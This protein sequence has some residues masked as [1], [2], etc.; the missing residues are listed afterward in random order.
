MMGCMMRMDSM[1]GST[2]GNEMRM[3]CKCKMARGVAPK[4]RPD[5]E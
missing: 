4:D 3:S 2:S 5:L 1:C